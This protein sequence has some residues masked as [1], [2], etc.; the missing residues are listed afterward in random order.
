MLTAIMCV[1]APIS[2]PIGSVP[3]NLGLFL[4]LLISLIENARI[5]TVVVMIYLVLGAFGIPVFASFRGGISV[6]LGPTGGFLLSY[7]IIP[8]F[9]S[10][11]KNKTIGMIISVIF[12]HIIGTLYFSYITETKLINS[13]YI[14]SLPF[15]IFDIAK[16]IGAY[17]L[18]NKMNTILKR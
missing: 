1:L 18:G 12:C 2:L 5:S 11:S 6:L 17:F 9:I 7:M 16:I 3:L 14:A 10:K 13:F 8:S 15:I 4:V